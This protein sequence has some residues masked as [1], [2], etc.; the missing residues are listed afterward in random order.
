MF[1]PFMCNL[2]NHPLA[3]TQGVPEEML[4]IKS[5]KNEG[6][7]RILNELVVAIYSVGDSGESSHGIGSFSSLGIMEL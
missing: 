4:F 7:N 6:S 3:V 2:F 1:V 5:L